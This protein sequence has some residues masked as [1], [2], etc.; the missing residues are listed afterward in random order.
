MLLLLFSRFLYDSHVRVCGV[1][2][3]SLFLMLFCSV[4]LCLLSF[5]TAGDT[6]K[7]SE[8]NPHHI[9]YA[10]VLTCLCICEYSCVFVN[11]PSSV[12]MCLTLFLCVSA[13]GY[14]FVPK[15][16]SI[17]LWLCVYVCCMHWLF[18]N[19]LSRSFRVS[20]G[21]LCA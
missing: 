5:M 16:L 13:H 15:N 20:L 1:G 4:R 12:C 21:V 18:Q 7:I 11:F 6:A 8:K 2:C 14:L 17:C 9:R 19:A 10:G 3:L